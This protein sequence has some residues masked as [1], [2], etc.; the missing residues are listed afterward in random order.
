MKKIVLYQNMHSAG[1]DLLKKNHCE[2][3]IAPSYEEDAVLPLVSDAD[4]III[5]AMGKVTKNII[6]AAPHLK[7][8]LLWQ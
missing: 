5:R 1:I 6:N 8:C 3:I 7:D 4:A 2:V